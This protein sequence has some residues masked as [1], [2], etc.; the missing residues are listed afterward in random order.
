MAKSPFFPGFTIRWDIPVAPK[1][2]L[3]RDGRAVSRS[4]YKDLFSVYGE[5]FGKGDG[6]T[7]FNLPD[8]RYYFPRGT[9]MVPSQAFATTAVDTTNDLIT[10]VGHRFNR[11]GFRVR[12]TT[13]NTL[14]SGISLATTY[15]VIW[16]SDDTFKLAS[17]EANALAGTAIDIT[18]QGTGTHT[19]SQ[20]MDTAA[21]TRTAL[22]TGGN[23]GDMP[24]TVQSESLGPHTH[25]T[26]FGTNGA[27]GT[28]LPSNPS[29]VP[30]SDLAITDSGTGLETRPMNIS[31]FWIV[32]Y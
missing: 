10:I 16:V 18:S 3:L 14:P 19:A 11:S 22:A 20:Y 26:Y 27:A 1:G 7:T 25:N 21:S 31:T 29:S 2:W 23:T 6:R 28:A 9:G 17:T 32:K 13:S 15:F 8:D 30:G 5:R 4:K 12:F 24:G